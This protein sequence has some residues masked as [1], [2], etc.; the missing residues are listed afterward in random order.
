MA[1]TKNAPRMTLQPSLLVLMTPHRENRKGASGASEQLVI[2]TW[3]TAG[4]PIGQGWWV[5][6]DE[7]QNN[8][9]NREMMPRYH[10]PGSL[11]SCAREVFCS[12]PMFRLVLSPLPCSKYQV[13]RAFFLVVMYIML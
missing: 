8:M 11:V 10:C 4:N 2:P 5:D 3:T 12:L 7:Q 1:T 13:G 6:N 9:D